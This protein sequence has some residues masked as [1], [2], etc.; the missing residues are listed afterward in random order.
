MPVAYRHYEKKQKVA[1]PR[2]TKRAYTVL[3]Q[4]VQWIPPG[5]AD[6]L[7]KEAKADIRSFSAFSHVLALL[8]GQITKAGSL[9]EICD[10]AKLHE[11]E[12]NRI[13]G[14]TAP[15]RNTFSNA[16]RTRDPKIAENLYWEVFKHLQEVCPGFTQHGKHKRFLFRMKRDIFAIDSTTLKLSLSCIDWARHRRKKAAAKTHMRLNVGTMLPSFAI[17][18]DAA[19]HDSKRA[20]AL[21]AG[22][23]DGDVL[24][25][26]RA[27]LDLAFLNGLQ[28]SGV[29]FVLRDKDNMVFD[30]VESRRHE[31]PSI[32]ADET[33]RSNSGEKYPGL[34]RRVTA[35]VE[36]DG[37]D[38]VM[39]FI[40]NNFAWSPRTIA[41]LYRARWAIELFFKELKQTLQ[42]NDFV[43][44]NENAVKWQVWIGLL[45]HLLIRFQKHISKWG[46]SFSRLAGTIRSA[47]WM[48]VDLA[49]TLRIYGTAGGPK[50][51]V[52]VEKQLYFRGFEPYSSRPVGQH[53]SQIT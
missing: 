13:R 25:A 12:L 7:A 6:S 26:D 33:V 14:A 47:I 42:L 39:S 22:L 30:V 2:P 29:F 4:L 9:N 1:T 17:V 28:Q 31:D 43:G 51:P 35:V 5:L 45:A 34:L 23:K 19:H 38:V 24:L 50:R 18:E 44:Y 8:H 21:C 46:L 15:K 49:V 37:K 48:K 32:I 41:E 16:N 40:T 36:V 3:R 10:A 53:M 20:D 11:P 27:Y 52:V